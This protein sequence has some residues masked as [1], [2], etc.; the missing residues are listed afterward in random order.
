MNIRAKE[1]TNPLRFW[2]AVP[3]FIA[4]FLLSFSIGADEQQSGKKS[5]QIKPTENLQLFSSAKIP[6]EGMSCMSCVAAIKKAIKNTDGV[7][8][9]E[10]NLVER[11]VKVD[12]LTSKVTAQAIAQKIN[13]LGYK[14]GSIDALGK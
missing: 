4:V 14:T 5:A 7:T 1:K 8:K 12:Y 2:K 13:D 9:V 10:V 6:V 11:N 3:L